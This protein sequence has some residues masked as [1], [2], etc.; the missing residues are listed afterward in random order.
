MKHTQRHKN[1]LLAFSHKDTNSAANF[2]MPDLSL[3]LSLFFVSLLCRYIV[4]GTETRKTKVK[5]IP[6]GYYK[7]KNKE[8]RR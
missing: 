1:R 8:A 6:N 3:F 5:K 7:T 2:T 4:I